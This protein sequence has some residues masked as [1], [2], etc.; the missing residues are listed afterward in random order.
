[1]SANAQSLSW[2]KNWNSS[3]NQQDQGYAITT[4][5]TGNVYV[6]GAANDGS[7]STTSYIE[8]I[9]YNS[10]G[11]IVW[12]T[13]YPS[14]GASHKNYGTAIAHD[15]HGNTWVAGTLYDGSA[16]H[17]ALIKYSPTGHIRP[18]YPK[19]YSD[20]PGTTAVPIQ[21]LFISVAQLMIT[22]LLNGH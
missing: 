16:N 5:A 9:K 13:A 20:S 21:L 2:A 15:A 22:L 12:S 18:F 4:D 3:S 19:T 17:L 7:G 6:T 1:L 14:G 10:S 11:T 8:T